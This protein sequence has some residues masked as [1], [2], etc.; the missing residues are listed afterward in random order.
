M[1]DYSNVEVGKLLNNVK[2]VARARARGNELF[3]SG[4]FSEACSAYGEGLKY[5]TSNSV[6]YCNRAVCWSKLG[7]WDK[8]VEDCN[9]ALK[10]QPNYT[11]ALL[12]RA[13][14]NGKVHMH[15]PFA[16]CVCACVYAFVFVFVFFCFFSSALFLNFDYFYIN[17]WHFFVGY[18]SLD[19][20]QRQ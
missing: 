3:S 12:R 5:D 2:L 1:I 4:R 20:G 6:L 16:S 15:S 10:I 7:L 9:H 11:K 17:C 19:N 14:S 13:V 8:S 18:C